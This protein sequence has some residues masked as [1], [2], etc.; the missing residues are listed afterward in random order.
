[1]SERSQVSGNALWRS[2]DTDAEGIWLTTNLPT[3]GLTGVCARDAYGS[4]KCA[5]KIDT[6]DYWRP[7]VNQFDS[8]WSNCLSTVVM[9]QIENDNFGLNKANVKI[10]KK[11]NKCK[12]CILSYWPFEEPFENT[13]WRKAKQMQPMWLCLLWSKCTVVT[14]EKTQWRKVEQMQPVWV[15]ILSSR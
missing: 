6:C 9:G 7:K 11:S 5:M 12:Q 2:I 14:F 4:K 3:N 13:Q 15:C 8:I 10:Q 1:M